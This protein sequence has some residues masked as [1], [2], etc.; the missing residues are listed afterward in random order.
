MTRL[1]VA[2]DFTM[3]ESLTSYCSRLAA[4]NNVTRSRSF[5][6][7]MGLRY[8][9]ISLGRPEAVELV[10]DLSGTDLGRLRK[11]TATRVGN[12]FHINGE[13]ITDTFFNRAEFRYCPHCLREDTDRGTGPIAARPYG[14]LAW[15]VG[16]VR[17]CRVHGVFLATLPG[18]INID[19]R[20]D[21]AAIW[22]E[23]SE[24]DRA[25]TCSQA[26]QSELE[27]Y[28]LRRL[29]GEPVSEG[30]IDTLPLYVVGHM[31]ETIGAA[32]TRGKNF[33]SKHLDVEAWHAAGDA[34]FR[35][36][37]EGK[38]GFGQ[39]LRSQQEEFLN[40]KR[41]PYAGQALYGTLY[42]RLEGLIEDPNYD[43]IRNFMRD[44]VMQ[45]LPFGPEDYLFGKLGLPRQIHSIKTASDQ[46]GLSVK[47]VRSRLLHTGVIAKEDLQTTPH[48]TFIDVASIDKMLEEMSD[49]Q[50]TGSKSATVE[51]KEAAAILGIGRNRWSGIARFFKLRDKKYARVSRRRL[52]A[53]LDDLKRAANVTSAPR[54]DLRDPSTA[55]S[56]CGCR[57]SEVLQLI[58]SRELKTVVLD[59]SRTGIAQLLVD[60]GEIWD[61]VH[62]ARKVKQHLTS[63]EAASILAIDSPTLTK[64]ALSG[65]LLRS[66]VPGT[67]RQFFYLKK[68]ILEFN[69]AYASTARIGSALGVS[70]LTAAAVLRKHDIEPEFGKIGAGA[71]L[72]RISSLGHVLDASAL[73]TLRSGIGP[74]DVGDRSTP[75]SAFASES[76]G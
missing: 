60:T 33:L 69:N 27:K 55:A 56:V 24:T 5:V 76:G 31:A 53:L 50:S 14:R 6:Q 57:V 3:G 64:L 17:T 48:R 58:L 65:V 52:E 34:G 61:W 72:Y 39:F 26:A 62:G 30:W 73:R 36:L 12:E 68:D 16:F 51:E 1:A 32:V 22:R 59:A 49:K 42:K 2:P 19:L 28:V 20:D 66:K 23:T 15:G 70:T 38:P 71:H 7:H 40:R 11:G 75:R 67:A 29:E 21:F 47:M 13:V 25:R 4:A 74:S 37:R 44:H 9:D 54:P 46:S 8:G 63:A 41:D 45:T 18:T 10:A 35:F 43:P